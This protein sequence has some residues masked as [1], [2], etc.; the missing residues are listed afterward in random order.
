MSKYR[1][2][3][4]DF[5]WIENNSSNK[6]VDKVVIERTI[7]PK[8]KE[9]SYYNNLPPIEQLNIQKYIGKKINIYDGYI[10]RNKV[11][12]LSNNIEIPEKYINERV[13]YDRNS[14]K[15]KMSPKMMEMVKRQV[16]GM[17]GYKLSRVYET[18]NSYRPVFESENEGIFEVNIK[19][20]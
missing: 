14:E 8:V 15:V 7:S 2:M 12:A 9:S 4:K 17:K 6:K 1:T 11:D 20:L 18:K 16:R 13:V 10:G 5:N 19:E 3:L